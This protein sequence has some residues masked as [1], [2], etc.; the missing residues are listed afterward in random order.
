M[1]LPNEIW[2][3]IFDHVSFHD[4]LNVRVLNAYFRAHLPSMQPTRF[5]EFTT[6]REFQSVLE[7]NRI[8]S[9]LSKCKSNDQKSSRCMKSFIRIG[10][11]CYCL[12]NTY[13]QWSRDKQKY[14]IRVFVRTRVTKSMRAEEGT[15]YILEQDLRSFS[16]GLLTNLEY[17]D[18]ME[19]K[20]QSNILKR[21]LKQGCTLKKIVDGTVG[22]NLDMGLEKKPPDD[23]YFQL[24]HWQI[25]SLIDDQ[26]VLVGQ[27]M[28]QISFGIKE[29]EALNRHIRVV[30]RRWI[31]LYN[32][33]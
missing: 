16:I 33:I 11:H 4:L 19:I 14:T 31:N 32:C 15:K 25:Y 27:E 26:I 21:M 1:D 8:A 5:I 23:A 30:A 18:E 6:V 10:K 12:L 7:N 9:I 20:D 2:G 3:K 28:G 29:L 22:C 17:L 24:P 13:H